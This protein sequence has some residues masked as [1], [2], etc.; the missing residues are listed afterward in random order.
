MTQNNG[1]ISVDLNKKVSVS[2]QIF[3][4]L[5]IQSLRY[6][7]GRMSLACMECAALIQHHWRD[8]DKSTKTTIIRDLDDE[9]EYHADYLKKQNEV[10]RLSSDLEYETWQELRKWINEQ[11]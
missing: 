1:W 6:C 11:A 4:M 9:L 8:L 2:N 3:Q 10:C 7:M 5:I